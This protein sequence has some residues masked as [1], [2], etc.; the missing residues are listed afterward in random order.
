MR[1]GRLATLYGFD[2]DLAGV[3]SSLGLPSPCEGAERM[4]V[5][6]ALAIQSLL[7]AWACL[8]RR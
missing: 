7:W 6:G 1:T 4:A 3:R 2:D 5:P 8:A